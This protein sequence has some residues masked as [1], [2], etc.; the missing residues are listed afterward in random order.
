METIIGRKSEKKILNNI[1]Y[2]KQA[3][4]LAIYG[5]RRVG[6]TFL[7]HEYCKDK[8]LYFDTTGQLNARLQDQLENF[9]Q[10]LESAFYHSI[11]IKRPKT[12]KEAFLQL[13]KAINDQNQNQPIILFFDEIPWLA[14]KRSG[15]ISALDYFWNTW[16]SRQSSIKLI[17]CG[18]ASA[19]IID[20]LINAKGGLH[21]R[22]T[23]TIH[24]Q[25]F[26][27]AESFLYL[28]SRGIHLNQKQVLDLYMVMGGIP[29]YLSQV[30]KG[31]S[32][33]QMINSLCFNK[34]GFL[35]SEFHRLFRSLFDHSDIHYKIIR[36]IAANNNHISRSKL[37]KDTGLTSGGRFNKRLQEL[38]ESGF[39]DIIAPYG[40]RK[41]EMIIKIIDEYT[42]FFLKWIEPMQTI[43]SIGTPNYWYNISKGAKFNVWSG[44]AFE[45]VCVKHVNQIIKALE[46][47]NLAAGVGR[48][49][50]SPPKK[51]NETGAQI[52]LL[53][54]RTDNVINLCEIKYSSE[55][56]KI[57][58]D[59]A[60]KLANKIMVFEEK[61][62]GNKQI[63]LTMITTFG[64][65]KSIW[66]EDLVDS[67]VLLADLFEIKL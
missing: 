22:L 24:L 63:F 66:S 28:T 5:R 23:Q 26:T 51:S 49:H 59:Y 25:A 32:A 27:L 8:G 15:F 12:W 45:A 18:S 57:N 19:W 36:A 16:A 30:Q 55:P 40:K 65:Q 50:F 39:I 61:S 20:K 2:S 60:K 3:E 43:S 44:Y 54:E 10:S 37:L 11:E 64:L 17:V 21:N 56:F 1:L 38:K 33:S 42:L 6:K 58:K 31:Q 46:I 48:W 62:K 34:D 41:K 47:E 53:I 67:E 13:K 9:S 52:D 35:F 14:T 29:H 7:I 4:F